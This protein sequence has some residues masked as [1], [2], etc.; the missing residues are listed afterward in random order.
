MLCRYGR[1]GARTE[2]AA[3]MRVAAAL[4]IGVTARSAT[5]QSLIF[6]AQA[7]RRSHVKRA[8]TRRSAAHVKLE[9][10]RPAHLVGS[11]QGD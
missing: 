1:S 3:R 11:L 10:E 9:T 2:P 4:F 7:S 6:S 8:L 5:L